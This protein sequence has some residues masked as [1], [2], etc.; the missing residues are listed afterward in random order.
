MTASNEK[1]TVPMAPAIANAIGIAPDGRVALQIDFA[2][3]EGNRTVFFTLDPELVFK[4]ADDLF[5]IAMQLKPEEGR[6][7]A[8]GEMDRMDLTR[9]VA[10]GS[11]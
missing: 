5:S 9:A 8:D 11:A 7:W 1:T 4:L 2:D 10:V 3:A 6:Q